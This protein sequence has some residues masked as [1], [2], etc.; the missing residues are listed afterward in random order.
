MEA[1]GKNCHRERAPRSFV[2]CLTIL[3]KILDRDD[4]EGINVQQADQC[5][6]RNRP[7]DQSQ[8]LSRLHR[9]YHRDMFR[10]A[11]EDMDAESQALYTSGAPIP[12]LSAKFGK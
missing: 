4:S 9:R 10:Q 8:I 2:F 6:S 12:A 11:G 3:I 5:S 7:E 1:I